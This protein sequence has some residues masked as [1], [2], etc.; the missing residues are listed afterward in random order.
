M[1]SGVHIKFHKVFMV[2]YIFCIIDS[3]SNNIQSLDGNSRITLHN[4]K[5][6][7]RA[8]F[9]QFF[10]VLY[11]EHVYLYKKKKVI[12]VQSGLPRLALSYLQASLIIPVKIEVA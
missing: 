3:T 8:H 10:E 4:L 2:M 9:F 7:A 1:K 11:Y 6:L 12:S 5:K